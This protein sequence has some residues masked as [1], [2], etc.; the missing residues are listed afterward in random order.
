MIMKI[1]YKNIRKPKN[2]MEALQTCERICIKWAN[3]YSRGNRQLFDDLKQCG[4]M[5][6]LEAFSRW[7]SN[8]NN[9]FA[10]Y[11]YTNVWHHTQHFINGQ[12]E[13][14]NKT[15][16]FNAEKDGDS[17]ELSTDSIDTEKVVDRLD[18]TSREV[19]FL[20]MEGETFDNIA[21][22]LNGI[23]NLQHA[24]NVYLEVQNKM[25]IKD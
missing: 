15:T 16:E 14:F 17:Y 24:R 11:A 20:R 7:D 22:R 19:F 8:K 12:W 2:E 5:A 13:V 25:E 3:R 9:A 10:T 1:E 18:S 21:N 6:V 4:Y 23:R